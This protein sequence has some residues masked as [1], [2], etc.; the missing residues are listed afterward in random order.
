MDDFPFFN[1]HSTQIWPCR[2]A[3]KQLVPPLRSL[4]PPLRNAISAPLRSARYTLPSPLHYVPLRHTLPS[5]FYQ[6]PRNKRVG[7]TKEAFLFCRLHVVQYEKSYSVPRRSRIHMRCPN[8]QTVNPAQAKF[9]LEC[10]YRF[11]VC[12]NCGTVNT[13]VA[14]FCIECGMALLAKGELTSP[15]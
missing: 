11:G 4:C 13:P 1:A 3:L 5:P 15:L 10:G 2:Q 8:C 6:V 7:S 12:P 9:C 14:K